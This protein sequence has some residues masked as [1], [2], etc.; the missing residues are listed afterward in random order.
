MGFMQIEM[1][2]GIL[3]GEQKVFPNQYYPHFFKND[4][5]E[6]RMLRKEYVR[7][8][9]DIEVARLKYLEVKGDFYR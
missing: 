1:N 3:E 8:R 2:R 6:I 9:N 7:L 4:Q 5:K